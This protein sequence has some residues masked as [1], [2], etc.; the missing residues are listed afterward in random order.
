MSTLL[1]DSPPRVEDKASQAEQFESATLSPEETTELFKRKIANAQED[2]DQHLDSQGVTT[3]MKPKLTLDLGH[4]NIA[5]L[6]ETVVDLIKE[7]VDRLSLSHNQLW[8]I[9]PRFSECNHLRY[10]NIRSNVFREIPRGVYKLPLLEILDISRNK[11]RKISRDIRNLTSLR[12]FAIVHNRV[13]DL[14]TELCEMNKLQILKIAENPLRFKLKKVVEQKENEVSFSEMTDNEREAAITVEIKRFLKESHPL[15]PADRR[16]CSSGVPFQPIGNSE[17]EQKSPQHSLSSHT[18][19]CLRRYLSR[20]EQIIPQS[21]RDSSSGACSISL[22][23]DFRP[24][25]GTQETR[26]CS[27]DQ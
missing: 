14:P 17:T 2:T 8:Y 5:R 16:R 20:G 18:K 15:V 12:V 6:P 10:L 22:P 21:G 23:N 27:T 19:H 13:D 3:V 7:E 11:V 25:N 24:R 4:C 1:D 26:H 9:P